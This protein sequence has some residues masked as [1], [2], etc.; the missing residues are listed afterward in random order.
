MKEYINRLARGN[1][2][3]ETPIINLSVNHIEEEVKTDED[4]CGEFLISAVGGEKIKGIVYSTNTLVSIEN[5]VFF[6]VENTI[7]YRVHANQME[8]D[9]CLEGKIEVVSL[10]GELSIPYQFRVCEN[11]V[12]SSMGKIHNLFHFTN[13][14]QA[15]EYEAERLFLSKEFEKV[16]LR[17]DERLKNIYQMLRSGKNVKHDI[18]EFL[19]CTNKKAEVVFG[20]SSSLVEFENLEENVSGKIVV[21]RNIWGDAS[22]NVWCDNDC[23]ELGA[24]S[25]E[26]D[27]FVGNKY[28][29]TYVIDITKC[30]AG[31]NFAVIHFESRKQHLT[32]QITI[33]QKTDNVQLDLEEKKY[34]CELM[35]LYKD[36]RLKR[37]PM[38]VWV[39]KSNNCVER[40]RAVNDSNPFYKLFHAQLLL[41]EKRKEDARWLI[42]YVQEHNFAKDSDVVKAYCL[43][44]NCMLRQDR[45]Y[46]RAVLETVKKFYEEG[47]AYWQIL[48]IIMYLDEDYERNKTLKLANIKEQY[49]KGCHSMIMY[50]EA[51]NV[52]NEQPVLLRVFD[53]FEIQVITFG[54]KED[55]LSEKLCAHICDLAQVKKA[56]SK[57]FA[58]MLENIFAR[59][60]NEALLAIICK[61]LIRSE[62][63]SKLAFGWYEK[64]VETE[65]K[66][67]NLYEYYL[68]SCDKSK[69]MKLPKMVLMYFKHN[70]LLDYNLRAF[71]YASVLTYKSVDDQIYELYRPQMENFVI[72]QIMKGH[73][74]DN[75]MIV[76]R[77]ILNPTLVKS[78]VAE[79]LWNLL[80]TYRLECMDSNMIRV[81][82]KHKE[83]DTPLEMRLV[84]GVAFIPIYT[85][86]AQV[87]F[88][89]AKGQRYVNSVEYRMERIVDESE[90]V[91][92]IR[93]FLLED[94]WFRLY[95]GEQS[96]RFDISIS[97]VIGNKKEIIK[98]SD[99]NK[100]TRIYYLR[101]LVQYYYDEYDGYEVDCS[102]IYNNF[103]ILDVA[104]R[105]MG[106]EICMLNG[107]FEQ[108]VDLI[109]EYGLCDCNPKRVLRLC[110]YLLDKADYEEDRTLLELCAYVF[111]HKKYDAEVLRYLVKY[112]NGPT[113]EMV[114]IWKEAGE[115]E[116]ERSAL[117]E[118]LI[119]QMMF[120]HSYS[121]NFER[122]FEDYYNAGARDRVADAYIAYN[123]YNY[124]VRDAVISSDVFRVIEHQ[125]RNDK[126]VINVA[127]LALLQH[128]TEIE[129]SE[130]QRR[131]AQALLEELCE[132]DIVFAFYRKFKG[133]LK[134][135]VYVRN[136]TIVEYAA[137]PN[138]HVEI[139]Y[140]HMGAE[141][142][143]EY[144]VED[145]KMMYDGMF[146][147]AFSL[148]Y[149]ESIQYYITEEYQ[150][151]IHHTESKVLVYEEMS[152]EVSEGKYEMINDILASRALGDEVTFEKMLR[153][154][155]VT[156]YVATQIF[157]I[158]TE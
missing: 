39:K 133:I 6:G 66:L 45:D 73:I 158:V 63:C 113:R 142:N 125:I 33:S 2:E 14:V 69:P 138:V 84:N 18:E 122:I 120:I 100:R 135:P 91:L 134:L 81:Y 7:C 148:F 104:Y 30:H 43:Y 143:K 44:L 11:R 145:M 37:I 97:D 98:N 129:L 105:R 76:Y 3:Y 95:M 121:N 23:I 153:G 118:R 136:A 141:G 48:W 132:K 117:S 80:F 31:K 103:S 124:F 32:C 109:K 26:G 114:E 152:E 61:N 131:L 47:S 70:S 24:T 9:Y 16:F 72:D 156:D 13:L 77:E 49:Y 75:L 155:A 17:G 53:E 60:N 68:Y 99:I 157:K 21:A 128:Y 146:V 8:R 58:K 115:F 71:L 25:I 67:T 89:D 34:L 150:G 28:E 64:G 10:G 29:L 19:I 59:L 27:M 56:Q 116:L 119:I 35:K 5:P 110:N 90:Y 12:D 38:P 40:L 106:L 1:I 79:K 101:E 93:E 82:V 123:S 50:L 83:F 36:F 54:I 52:W 46:A 144:A 92:R 154:Y 102:F 112:Y 149:G 15:E 137:N 140:I 86:N 57:P 139:H 87:I 41:A 85:E 78:G 42:E 88:E 96:Y 107:C 130:E 94:I 62:D 147:K 65:L 151:E 127:K 22:L 111:C 108:A 20:I 51:L 4:F 126:D 74:N 55:M